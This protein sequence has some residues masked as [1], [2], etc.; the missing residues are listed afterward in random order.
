MEKGRKGLNDCTPWEMFKIQLSDKRY[1]WINESLDK[2]DLFV[3]DVMVKEEA[4]NIQVESTE[5]KKGWWW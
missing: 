5:V 2:M 4:E 3:G 1:E